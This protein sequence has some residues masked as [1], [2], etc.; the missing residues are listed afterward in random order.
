MSLDVK[1]EYRTCVV[2]AMNNAKDERTLQEE[3]RTIEVAAEPSTAAASSGAAPAVRAEEVAALPPKKL[4]QPLGAGHQAAIV[5]RGRVGGRDQ[6]TVP[7]AGNGE[8]DGSKPAVKAAKGKQHAKATKE[9]EDSESKISGPPTTS[10]D[11][12]GTRDSKK[13]QCT[14]SRLDTAGVANTTSR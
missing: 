5:G 3:T 10:A 7:V 2:A 6:G 4:C 11:L 12:L 9:M 14:K 1:A 13:K 8:D